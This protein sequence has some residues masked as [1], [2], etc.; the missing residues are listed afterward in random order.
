MRYFK[1]KD[2]SIIGKMD[3]I[4]EEQAKAYLDDGCKECDADG[5]EM[6]SKSKKRK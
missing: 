5:K 4:S 2:G 1:K 3:S 6:K